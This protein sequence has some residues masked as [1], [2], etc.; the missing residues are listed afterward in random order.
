M[1]SREAAQVFAFLFKGSA[2]ATSEGIKAG[3]DGPFTY[4]LWDCSYLSPQDNWPCR[5]VRSI[6]QLVKLH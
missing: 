1:H 5:T 2:E 6:E 3:A 4:I